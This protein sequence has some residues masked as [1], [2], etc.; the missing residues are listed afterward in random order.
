MVVCHFSLR[1]M[2][3]SLPSEKYCMSSGSRSTCSILSVIWPPCPLAQFW[4]EESVGRGL[5][6]NIKTLCQPWEAGV[7]E[8]AM[9]ETTSSMGLSS[10]EGS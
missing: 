4:I 3:S 10:E 2:A 9:L 5:S 6:P 8:K 7:D 1:E